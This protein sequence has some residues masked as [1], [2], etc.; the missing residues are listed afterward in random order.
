MS[1]I[2]TTDPTEGTPLCAVP[3]WCVV[4]G[5]PYGLYGQNSNKWKR[6]RVSSDHRRRRAA[7]GNERRPINFDKWNTWE[8]GGE[9]YG[10]GVLHN[11]ENGY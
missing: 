10:K 4:S 5:M 8:F 11:F 9:A 6:C 2:S 3:K 1:F 7:G